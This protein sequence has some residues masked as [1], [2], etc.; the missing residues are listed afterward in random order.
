ACLEL[1]VPPGP[2]EG[3]ERVNG[4]VGNVARFP[5]VEIGTEDQNWVLLEDLA[6]VSRHS[7]RSR[8]ETASLKRGTASASHLS[9]GNIAET[10]V[11]GE[12]CLREYQGEFGIGVRDIERSLIWTGLTDVTAGVEELAGFL[13]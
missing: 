3:H 10:C 9:F 12:Q 5:Q 11:I 8:H 1:I 4:P 6:H 7:V 2:S 13:E